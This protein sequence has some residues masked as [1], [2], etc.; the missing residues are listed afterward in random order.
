MER[1]NNNNHTHTHMTYLILYLGFRK[2]DEIKIKLG[3]N[4]AI[5]DFVI[6]GM[7]NSSNTVQQYLVL[8]KKVF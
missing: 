6:Y 1:Y 5:L 4:K 2:F 8:E 3:F 7:K